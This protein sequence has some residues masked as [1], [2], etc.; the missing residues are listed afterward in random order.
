MI[1]YSCL[2]RVEHY[3][4]VDVSSVALESI[5]NELTDAERQK[6]TL[7]NR[8]ADQLDAVADSSC[9]LVIINSVAQYF[10]SADYLTNVLAQAA[11]VLVAGGAVFVGDVRCL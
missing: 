9:D 8:A 5:R 11:R 2:E 6:V 4:A 10:P 1:L 7:L 3:T